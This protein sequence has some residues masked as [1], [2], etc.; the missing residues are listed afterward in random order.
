MHDLEG[1]GSIIVKSDVLAV[2][3]EVL[4]DRRSVDIVLIGTSLTLDTYT[5]IGG[6]IVN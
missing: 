3:L 4:D 2:L 6:V 5:S 1:V